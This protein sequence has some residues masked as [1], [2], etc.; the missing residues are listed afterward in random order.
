[1]KFVAGAVDWRMLVDFG[2][3]SK[4]VAF[5][6]KK[7]LKTDTSVVYVD[8]DSVYIQRGSVRYRLNINDARERIDLYVQLQFPKEEGQDQ[9]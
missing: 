5:V 3:R 9:H 6:T 7:L 1:M 4:V 2:W 8:G